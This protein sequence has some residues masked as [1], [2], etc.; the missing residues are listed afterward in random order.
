M[1]PSHSTRIAQLLDERRQV[2]ERLGEFPAQ[3]YFEPFSIRYSQLPLSNGGGMK[4]PAL[5]SGL[6]AEPLEPLDTDPL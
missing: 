6:L 3:G 5:F 2:S 4:S 1:C